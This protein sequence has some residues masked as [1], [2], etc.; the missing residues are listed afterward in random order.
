M[1]NTTSFALHMKKEC[2]SRAACGLIAHVVVAA[3]SCRTL[4]LAR[5]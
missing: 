1:Q 5:M 2:L 4:T 3:A